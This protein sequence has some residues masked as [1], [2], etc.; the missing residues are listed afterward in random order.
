[1]VLEVILLAV[2]LAR[3]SP[4]RWQLAPFPLLAVMFVALETFGTWFLLLPYYTGM[5]SHSVSGGLPAARLAQ[6][7]EMGGAAFFA[8]LA[9]NKPGF[10]TAPVVMTITEIGRAH[11]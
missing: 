1:M 3:L 9:V 7:A 11:V 2:G 10:L 8:N 5:T 4:P 6:F